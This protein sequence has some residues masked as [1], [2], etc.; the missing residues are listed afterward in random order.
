MDLEC[1]LP[2]AVPKVHI[3][4]N[5]NGSD[6]RP[7]DAQSLI[8]NCELPA[9]LPRDNTKMQEPLSRSMT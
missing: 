8:T 4:T 9:K 1:I 6:S 5:Y 2:T 3:C 7:A